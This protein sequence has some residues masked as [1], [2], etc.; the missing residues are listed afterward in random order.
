MRVHRLHLTDVTPSPDLPW[1]RP[2][3]PVYAFLVEHADGPVLID[4]GVGVGNELIDKLYS[5]VHHDLDE[6]LSR[7]EIGVSDV[8]TV[9]NSH[10]HFDHCG[11]NHRFPQ[12]RVIVQATEVEVAREP[13]YTVPEWAFPTDVNLTE[14]EGDHELA[15][16]ITIIATPGHTP[17][18]QSVLIEDDDGQRTIVCCQASWDIESFDAA[19]LGDDGWDQAAGAA[20]ATRL[21]AFRPATVLLS[22]DPRTWRPRE[23]SSGVD[24]PI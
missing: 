1:A 20:S 3:F 19:V 12:A 9:I 15:P 2:T 23:I 11:Q 16:G 4:T 8:V 24:V 6:A 17:G 18:H 14:I 10:L 21:H 22:H 7:Y 13:L 5:P